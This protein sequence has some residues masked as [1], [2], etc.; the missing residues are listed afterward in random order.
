[1]KRMVF[2]ACACSWLGQLPT[3]APC[4][5][6][7]LS[8]YDRISPERATMLEALAQRPAPL[9]EK[10]MMRRAFLKLGI[11]APG[12][13]RRPP[14]GDGKRRPPAQLFA[15]TLRGQRALA[16]YRDLVAMQRA[17]AERKAQDERDQQL[18]RSIAA[19]AAAR[20]ADLLG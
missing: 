3:R 19:E 2:A 12:S 5:A 4:P 6:C 10:P 17:E 13:E 9:A 15:L 1:M 20:H 14:G 8:H 16:A 11:V 18:R 7:G